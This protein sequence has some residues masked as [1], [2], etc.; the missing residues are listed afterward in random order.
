MRMNPG[1]WVSM[2]ICR[3]YVLVW[4][5]SINQSYAANKEPWEW[6]ETRQ[7]YGMEPHLI[8][9]ISNIWYARKV[10]LKV[11]GAAIIS[12]HRTN[13]INVCC[14]WY[15]LY[16]LIAVHTRENTNYF[17]YS[18]HLNFF[19]HVSDNWQIIKLYITWNETRTNYH[20]FFNVTWCF[21]GY[22][23]VWPIWT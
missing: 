12:Q 17:V 11:M 9:N 10:N 7:I 2:I 8:A 18:N 20:W 14:S 1:V 16:I 6:K 23:F 15:A 19:V 13:M 5:I 22:R 3:V 4:R 21:A